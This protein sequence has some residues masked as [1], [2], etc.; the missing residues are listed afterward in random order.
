MRRLGDRPS[1]G[2]SP[3]LGL[4]QDVAEARA[5]ENAGV[6]SLEPLIEPGK[7]LDVKALP[8]PG[9]AVLSH[10]RDLQMLAVVQLLVG[11]ESMRQMEWHVLPVASHIDWHLDAI[12]QGKQIAILPPGI[13]K[14]MLSGDSAP[15]V[16]PGMRIVVQ[17]EQ[18]FEAGDCG[19][20][21]GHLEFL[22]NAGSQ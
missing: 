4:G 13:T 7:S 9:E 21:I 17:F 19:L 6:L 10:H 1:I 8:R 20:A 11:G 18:D 22:V 14:R 16:I 15:E 5:V 3:A 12:E 2:R